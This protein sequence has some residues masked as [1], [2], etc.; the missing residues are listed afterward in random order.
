MDG[1]G[2]SGRV[3]RVQKTGFKQGLRPFEIEAR[4]DCEAEEFP[5]FGLAGHD[6][7]EPF[8]YVT[9]GGF[10]R[11]GFL[12]ESSLKETAQLG[13]LARSPGFHEQELILTDDA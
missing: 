9:V 8:K 6:I 13:E 10:H 2:E 5:Y 1:I 4:T 11:I 7:A 3:D 12:P